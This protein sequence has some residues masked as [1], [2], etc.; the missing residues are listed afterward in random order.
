MHTVLYLDVLIFLNAFVTAVLLLATAA[1]LKLRLDK[2]RLILATALG[3]ALSLVIFLPQIN[4]AFGLLIKGVG[5]VLLSLAAFKWSTWRVFLRVSAGFLLANFI[6][7]GT[8]LALWSLLAPRGMYYN[9]GAVYWEIS[10]LL[11]CVSTILCYAVLRLVNFLIKRKAPTNHIFEMTLDMGSQSVTLQALFDSGSSLRE[12]FS[13]AAVI[14]VQMDSIKKLVPRGV[15]EYYSK[16]QSAY[17]SLD[18]PVH[19][20]RLVPYSSV[21]GAGV[22]P[23]FKADK[24]TLCQ[25][26]KT[27]S[28][29]ETYI[30]VS[31]K[32]LG[33]GEFLALVGENFFS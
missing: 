31:G 7:A 12:S 27:W 21:G 6:F 30:A 23:A 9:N 17:L 13:G 22:L 14:L 19:P 2:W 20:L 15:K 32:D 1:I 8:M 10:V 4:V 16:T 11:L 5:C 29:H 25:G 18:E 26:K 33:R 24:V 3:G 28:S